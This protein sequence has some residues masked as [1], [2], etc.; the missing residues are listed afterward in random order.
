MHSL[1]ERKLSREAKTVA[2]LKFMLLQL[3]P[4]LA[5]KFVLLQPKPGLAHNDPPKRKFLYRKFH[6]CPPEYGCRYGNFITHEACTHFLPA[7]QR[8]LLHATVTKCL[9]S[10]CKQAS[11]LLKI[12]LQT[13]RSHFSVSVTFQCMQCM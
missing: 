6:C 3:K 9:P 2:V 13:R 11:H 12:T 4:G 5:S 7:V 8:N 1:H 10:G